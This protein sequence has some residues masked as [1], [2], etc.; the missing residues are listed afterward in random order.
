MRNSEFVQ[1]SS[2][3]L[4]P[5]TIAYAAMK[6]TATAGTT[7]PI[8]TMTLLTKYCTKSDSMTSR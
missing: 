2:L 4:P 7:A 5:R 8:V 6:L 1:R 3:L